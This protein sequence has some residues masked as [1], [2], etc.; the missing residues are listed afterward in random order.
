MNFQFYEKLLITPS[1][2]WHYHYL[3]PPAPSPALQAP[4]AKGDRRSHRR[5]NSRPV[6]NDANPWLPKCDLPHCF[7]ANTEPSREP[8]FDTVLV[9]CCSRGRH[10]VVHIKLE[11]GIE[12]WA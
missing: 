7:D 8:G 11:S 3:L 10:A 1:T 9:P 2:G 5:Y 12:C 6:R 4:P